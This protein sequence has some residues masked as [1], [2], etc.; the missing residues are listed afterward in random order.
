METGARFEIRD[1]RVCRTD[2]VYGWCDG[3]AGAD[4]LAAFAALEQ[5]FKSA[6]DR[7]VRDDTA[8]REEALRRGAHFW[9]CFRLTH[10][11]AQF[12]LR[13]RADFSGQCHQNRGNSANGS[14]P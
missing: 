10:G 6:C 7:D 1:G 4:A 3:T 5:A 11:V 13:G 2:A 8:A 12:G 14:L 9:R